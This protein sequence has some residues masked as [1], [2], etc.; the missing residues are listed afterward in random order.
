M[1]FCGPSYKESILFQLKYMNNE[2]EKITLKIFFCKFI[3]IQRLWYLKK[4]LKLNIIRRRLLWNTDNDLLIL[5]NNIITSLAHVSQSK[6]HVTLTVKCYLSLKIIIE[7]EITHR[8]KYFF[9]NLL[10]MTTFLSWNRDLFTFETVSNFRA[11]KHKKIFEFHK[12]KKNS[13]GISR[14]SAVVLS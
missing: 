5:I 7:T 12:N 11:K 3:P 14:N 10:V 13:G 1:S 9:R 2:M 8:G 4:N 6:S